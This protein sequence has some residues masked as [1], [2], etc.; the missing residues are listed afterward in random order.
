MAALE[1]KRSSTLAQI[2][3]ATLNEA[4]VELVTKL[5]NDHS[6]SSSKSNMQINSNKQER[7]KKIFSTGFNPKESTEKLM[8]DSSFSK[9]QMVSHVRER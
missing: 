5:E 1:S 4:Q 7:I 6:A 2:M 8:N 3:E 9:T